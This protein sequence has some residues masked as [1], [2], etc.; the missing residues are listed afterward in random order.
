MPPAR[1]SSPKD[2]G[3]NPS[4]SSS[5]G[6][7]PRRAR[8]HGPREA[9]DLPSGGVPL[10]A[11]GQARRSAKR[12]PRAA[13]SAPGPGT[14]GQGPG[15][16]ANSAGGLQDPS[17][18]LNRELSW[19]EFNARVLEQARDPS[20]PLL[21][22]LRFLAISSAN[23]DEFYE[24]RVAGLQQQAAF[25]IPTGE[26]DG[27]SPAAILERISETAH[28]LVEQQYEVLN[29]ELLPALRAAGV[30]LLDSDGWTA[31]QGRWLKRYFKS[32]VLP[33]LTPVGLDPAHPFPRILNKSLTFIVSVTGR[34]DFG[35]D[36]GVAVVQVPRSLPRLIQLPPGEGFG[37]HD[38]VLLSSIVHAHI[39]EA[40]GGM[41]VTSCA[42]FRLTRNSDLWVDEEEADDLMR[43]LKGELSSR[44]YG[45]A[46]RLEVES[47]CTTEMGE[48]LLSTF[49][50]EPSVMFR[51]PGPVNLHRVLAIH[52]LCQ[53][54]DLK[55]PAFAGRVQPRLEH[56]RDLF[57]VL[58][59]G[60]VLLHHPFDAF[61]PVVEFLRQAALDPAVLAIK[62]T[63]YRTGPD[64]PIVETLIEAARAGKEVT[65]VVELR[66]RFDEA[67]NISL[68]TRLQQAGANVVYGIV[69][70][71]AHAKMLLVVR[72][73]ERGLRRYVHL[74][75][76][77]Y[78]VRT[79]K[80][81]TDFS[82]LTA[83]RG[84]GNDVHKL[85]LQLTGLGR[86]GKLRSLYQAP[87][88][89]HK[90]LLLLIDAE[91]ASARA[92][93]PARIVAKM[94]S[95]AEPQV[96]QA[97]YRASQ[98]GVSIDLIVRGLCCLR[99]GVPH[100]SDNIRVRSIVGR[101]LEHSRIFYFH[102]GGEPR[103]FCSSADWMQRNFFRRVEACFPIEDERVKERVI[104]EG[105]ELY[106][107]D[108]TQ[109][110]SL[111]SDGRYRRLRPGRERPRSAQQS[112]LE[113]LCGLPDTQHD[114]DVGQDASL[115]LQVRAGEGVALEPIRRK[116]ELDRELPDAQAQRGQGPGAAAA[117]EPGGEPQKNAELERQR[118]A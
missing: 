109:A 96:I 71:K 84:I 90:E 23:L 19:L 80:A 58:R 15:S 2:P 37:P 24:I 89:L 113:A 42:A 118:R 97:L 51:V 43:A 94:N 74:G 48:F 57:L 30:R 101:M 6:G 5:L 64:S 4:E 115:L 73:E 41:Q 70:Y 52:E 3:R 59:R 29:G 99:P 38:F 53:R 56:E 67:A 34:D 62:Q 111:S 78:H 11:P 60:D 75:T 98:A 86:V 110:W 63:L 106:L 79:A 72:R 33:V 35:R 103:V 107:H 7:Q 91:A 32:Q 28:R 40:F 36:S 76:G 82:L 108:N 102:N 10:E 12:A 9:G 54:P 93:R 13:P 116:E 68:A 45:D 18:Y 81:Y 8:E 25:G 20:V 66:A 16:G 47:E 92:G 100:V 46:V 83:D 31:S 27:L 44:N 22:R 26:P 49:E 85:F 69:G 17:L 95:L 104:S 55:F 50:L 117:I 105:L 114:A 77:N 65:V 1:D 14:S 88:T 112:L 87:F 21:E 61:T 39:G